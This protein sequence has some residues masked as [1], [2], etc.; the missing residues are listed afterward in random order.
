MKKCL[1]VSGGYL[2]HRAGEAADRLAALLVA[3]GL[4]VTT[5]DSLTSY[6]TENLEAF[7]LIVPNWT[8]G[9]ISEEVGQR[10][11]A[12]VEGGVGL[13]GFHGGMAD[14]F[15]GNEFFRFVVGGSYVAEPGGASVTYKVHIADGNDPI[16]RGIADFDYTSEQYYMHVDPA[17]R[18]L[19]TTHFTGDTFPWIDGVDMPTVWTKAY[20]R[21][22]VFFSALG[23]LPEEFD[24]APMRSLLTRG[25]L[26]ACR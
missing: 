19:A 1:I 17:V 7:D 15:R 20:G 8:L 6:E 26:W 14:G 10:L 16:T 25:L 12:A 4:T 24:C 18:V 3:E 21:G 2:P 9:E 22:R 5:S 23:H 13:G 11:A